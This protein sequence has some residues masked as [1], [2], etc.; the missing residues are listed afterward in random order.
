M[1]EW[2][3]PSERGVCVCPYKCFNITDKVI[4]SRRAKSTCVSYYSPLSIFLPIWTSDVTRHWSWRLNHRGFHRHEQ[5]VAE[6]CY[7]I[8]PC[9][10]IVCEWRNFG[11]ELKTSVLRSI[12]I[13]KPP[14]YRLGSWMGVRRKE[15]TSPARSVFYAETTPWWFTNGNGLPEY[16]RVRYIV[17]AGIAW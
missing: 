2:V 9:R 16:Y 15:L 11:P 13:R 10:D 7:R 4:F 3:G 1:R 5:F 14:L 8:L 12:S 17:P 6:T